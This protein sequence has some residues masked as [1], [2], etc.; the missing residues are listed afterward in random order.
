MNLLGKLIKKLHLQLQNASAMTLSW[1][2]LVSAVSQFHVALSLSWSISDR[3]QMAS[4]RTSTCLIHKIWSPIGDEFHN[5]KQ[6]LDFLT[7]I[8]IPDQHQVVRINVIVWCHLAL[9]CPQEL[10]FTLI[11][12]TQHDCQKSV[13][14]CAQKHLHSMPTIETGFIQICP[15]LWEANY[16]LVFDAS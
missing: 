12:D 3:H 15:T 10:L 8:S 6:Q 14:Q 7:S 9:L 2:S 1:L 5:H 16:C 11:Q 4:M 13:L